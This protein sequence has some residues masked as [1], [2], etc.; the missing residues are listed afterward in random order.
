MD[1]R[2][3]L[4][5]LREADLE[6]SIL[7]DARAAAWAQATRTTTDPTQSGVRTRSDPHRFDALAALDDELT[8]RVNELAAA[9]T[10]AVQMIYSLDNPKYR[11]VMTAYYIDCRTP[12]G[13]RKTWEM[14]AAELF[15]SF[16]N[17]MVTHRK[18][19]A[20]LENSYPGGAPAGAV[21]SGHGGY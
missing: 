17:A 4:Q 9:K 14:V 15:C 12:E 10:A 8:R 21:Q 7:E 11:E 1:I 19:L 2:Q 3:T 6:I 5:Q 20:A 16:G 18:A 13:T